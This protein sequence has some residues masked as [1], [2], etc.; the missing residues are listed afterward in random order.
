MIWKLVQ[1]HH[2]SSVF[3]VDC[4]LLVKNIA[5]GCC[6]RWV[7]NSINLP[8]HFEQSLHTNDSINIFW[9]LSQKLKPLVKK[10]Q[11]HFMSRWWAGRYVLS[12][13]KVHFHLFRFLLTYLKI[14]YCILRPLRIKSKRS[15]IFSRLSKLNISF[16]QNRSEISSIK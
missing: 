16:K 7:V 5:N 4:I 11:C 6:I 9:S 2:S 8:N 13:V 12:L 1:L 15:F 14:K 3:Q 10:R